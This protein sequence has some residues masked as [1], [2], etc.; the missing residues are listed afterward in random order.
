MRFTFKCMIIKRPG[1]TV[2]ST[3][4]TSLLILSYL[5]RI[6]ELPYYRMINQVDF[7]PFFDGIWLV[8]ISMSTVGFGDI[9]PFTIIGRAVVIF[10]AIW[11]AFIITLVL[12]AFSS[13]FNLS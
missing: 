8:V 3:L 9:V 5:L 7:E 13:L 4:I 12:V 6:F 2:L 1:I 10:S 11:G